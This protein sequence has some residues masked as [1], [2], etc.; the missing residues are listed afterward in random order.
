MYTL[1]YM[2]MLTYSPTH[3]NMFKIYSLTYKLLIHIDTLVYIHT[4]LLTRS[5]T[6]MIM[7]TN[8]LRYIDVPDTPSHTL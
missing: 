4:R 7:L 5:L 6:H 2:H 8:V 3:G 1:T